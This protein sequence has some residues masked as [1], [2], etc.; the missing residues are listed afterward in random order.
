[1]PDSAAGYQVAQVRMIFRPNVHSGHMLHG[2]HLAYV[3]W[4]MTPEGPQKDNNMYTVQRLLTS[5]GTR[6]EDVIDILSIARF[7]QLIPRF[8]RSVSSLID[9]ENSMEIVKSYYINSFADKDIF[10]TVW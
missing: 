2:R 10:Q 6:R 7:V 5:E 8:G 3:Q 1:V 4:F 9:C